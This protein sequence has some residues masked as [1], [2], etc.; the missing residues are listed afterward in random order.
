[1]RVAILGAGNGGIC[2]GGYM[3]LKGAEV[4]L[5]DKFE[6]AV[7]PIVERGGVELKGASLNGFARFAKVSTNLAEIV[8]GAELIRVI[9]PAFA[10]KELAQLCGPHLTKGQTVILNPGRT[11]GA[12]EFYKTARENGATDFRVAETQSLIY[13][14]RVSAPAEGTIYKVKSEMELAAMPSCDTEK[15]LEVIR[16]FYPQFIP[17]K[18]SRRWAP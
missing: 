15:V 11:C 5:Y 1:M 16:P 17:A 14:C 8:D 13:A 4:T 9:T 6:K 2:I 10:H 3:A 7:A 18:W 12:I